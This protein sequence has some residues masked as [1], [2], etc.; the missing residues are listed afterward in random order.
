MIIIED[1][2]NEVILLT[3]VCF[4]CLNVCQN[5]VFLSENNTLAFF[6]CRILWVCQCCQ[7]VLNIF[8]LLERT[9]IILISLLFW[10]STSYTNGFIPLRPLIKN[11][12][13]DC[14]SQCRISSNCGIIFS[15]S[16]AC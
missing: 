3:V 15:N 5:S 8:C 6:C 9:P 7:K 2:L 14:S 1:G 4:I 12:P 13:S 11:T 16:L 10:V